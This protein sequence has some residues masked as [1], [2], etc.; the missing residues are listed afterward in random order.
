MGKGIYQLF[1]R[2]AILL[3][4]LVI[5]TFCSSLLRIKYIE[6]LQMIICLPL[7]IWYIRAYPYCGKLYPYRIVFLILS[8]ILLYLIQNDGLLVNLFP[9]IKCILPF[10]MWQLKLNILMGVW[11][12]GLIFS[13]LMILGIFLGALVTCW[14]PLMFIIVADLILIFF[15][16]IF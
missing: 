13:P 5:V 7:F 4:S 3:T 6:I 12:K 11:I 15:K 10:P 2:G 14:F 16:N 1:L 9:S 8:W